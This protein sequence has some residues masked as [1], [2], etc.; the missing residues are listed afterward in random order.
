MKGL[1]LYPNAE[2]RL[3]NV[4]EPKIGR[5][6]YSPN[7]TILEVRY[8]GVC[9]SD[10]HYWRNKGRIKGPKKPVVTGHEVSAV[11][12]E[13]GEN[14]K[15]FKAGDRVV[16][17]IVTFFCGKCINCKQGKVNI[18]CNIQPREQRVHYT[19]GGGF[20]KYAAWPSYS[21]HKLP[22]SISDEEAV[23]I[24]TTAGSVHSLIERAKLSAGESVAILGPGARGL[25][26][27]QVA[28]AVGAYPVIVTGTTT[29]EER[30]L[31]L[32]EELGADI[33][34]NVEKEDLEKVVK[35]AT[36]NWGVDVVME[37]AGTSKAVLQG[38]KII[39]PGGRLIVSG[40]GIVGGISITLDTYDLIVKEITILGEIS[41]IWTSWRTAIKLVSSGKVKLKRLIS[42]VFPLSRWEEAFNTALNSKEALRVVIKPE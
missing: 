9:G 39:R 42:H 13:V 29:D 41:H 36:N 5:N 38:Y 20:A 30:R 34:V 7:D 31:K 21:L 25:I 24:E 19:T 35:E 33:V 37:A 32:A 15:D 6:P 12:K 2:F 22:D 18:C 14:V 11:V 23:L 27:L 1:V 17:E 8:C 10:L 16:G 28:K 26:L 40:G 4:K 3:E